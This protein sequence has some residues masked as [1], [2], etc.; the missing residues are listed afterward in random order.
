LQNLVLSTAGMENFL[1]ELAVLAARTVD[2][3]L[4]CGITTQPPNGGP[5]TVASSEARQIGR[6]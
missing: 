4:I 1:Q 6:R 2:G 3:G 5:V